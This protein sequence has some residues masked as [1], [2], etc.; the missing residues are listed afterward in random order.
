MTPK[1]FILCYEATVQSRRVWAVRVGR[2]WRTT[3]MVEVNVPM[4][5]VFLGPQAR[6]PKAYLRG[7][8]VVRGNVNVLRIDAQ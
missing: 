1:P 3:R 7:V 5:T 6:Q 4:V 8:G 2:K